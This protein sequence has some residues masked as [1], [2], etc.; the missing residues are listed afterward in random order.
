MPAPGE[1]YF[2]PFE[3]SPFGIDRQEV[4]LI[5]VDD[6]CQGDQAIAAASKLVADGV[7]VRRA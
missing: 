2:G 7:A 5:A 4:R 1:I 3:E 6:F